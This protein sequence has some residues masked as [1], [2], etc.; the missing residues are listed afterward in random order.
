MLDEP[1]TEPADGMSE[2]EQQ[3]EEEL[4]EAR[5]RAAD[6][7]RMIDSL[8]QQVVQLRAELAARSAAQAAAAAAAPPASTEPIQPQPSREPVAAQPVPQLVPQQR[9]WTEDPG[10]ERPSWTAPAAPAATAM[11]S[12]ATADPQSFL[13]SLRAAYAS[14]FPT[15]PSPSER[16][17]FD[18]FTGDVVKWSASQQRALRIPVTWTVRFVRAERGTAKDRT[19]RLIARAVQRS[20]AQGPSDTFVVRV[21]KADATELMQ[22]NW[23]EE[24][25]E[26]IGTL[27]PIVR[28]APER[29]YDGISS[30]PSAFVGPYCEVSIAIDSQT[31][32][33]GR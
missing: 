29:P 20:S 21:P 2:R 14:R 12:S 33:P 27:A 17:A 19:V 32:G 31:I 13:V 3:L 28:F 26:V 10:D 9:S 11:T 5:A 8:R 30:T 1:P 4:A 7:E 24:T 23:R 25:F 15:I 16:G 22:G 18:A 6:L